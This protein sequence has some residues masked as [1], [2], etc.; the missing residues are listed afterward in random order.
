MKTI[1]LPAFVDKVSEPLEFP[2]IAELLVM[3]MFHKVSPEDLR[4]H[5]T[6]FQ[7]KI[8]DTV[9][10]KNNTAHIAIY[11]IVQFLYPDVRANG[12]LLGGQ[13][14]NEWHV[15][16]GQNSNSTWHIIMNDC[17][18]R[19]VFSKYSLEV[20]EDDYTNRN[21]KG[22]NR[23]LNV[24]DKYPITPQMIEP[25]R[26]HSF[27]H[28]HVHKA[29]TPSKPQFRFF[30]RVLETDYIPPQPIEKAMGFSH[31]YLPEGG[32]MESIRRTDNGFSITYR[33]E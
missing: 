33:G 32:S 24:S 9:P 20:E 2:D 3:P 29:T 1:I 5:G 23:L 31:V 6:D 27:T 16:R 12:L 28:L 18:S 10:L 25:N 11:S 4:K 17:Q 13:V 30:F 22:F 19:T 21:G 14:E 7:K 26:V 8:L 15:D